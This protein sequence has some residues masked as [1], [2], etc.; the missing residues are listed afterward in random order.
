MLAT[1]DPYFAYNCKNVQGCVQ[2]PIQ[3]WYIVYR[4]I[5][6]QIVYKVLSE[7]ERSRKKYPTWIALNE[8]E[9]FGFLPQVLQRRWCNVAT[10][11]LCYLHLYIYP[12][13]SLY[14]YTYIFRRKQVDRCRRRGWSWADVA[15]V[16]R[17]TRR[18]RSREFGRLV[19]YWLS[20][21]HIPIGVALHIWPTHELLKEQEINTSFRPGGYTGVI[22]SG[23]AHGTSF[24]WIGW[25]QKW[26]L[27][28]VH[29]R[30]SKTSAV[31]DYI[32]LTV[33]RI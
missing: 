20:L 5:Q 30:V 33:S 21:F 2:V 27:D 29:Q 26:M 31:H 1:I 16:Y 4:P 14:I 28:L 17:Y 22:H 15:T 19:R 3:K 11:S 12:S 13:F 8:F 18:L 32:F 24:R 25:W 9:S 10:C 23:Q 6:Y 7:E